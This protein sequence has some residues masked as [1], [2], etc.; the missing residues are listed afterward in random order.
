MCNM[1]ML[2]NKDW[3]LDIHYG[4]QLKGLKGL[5]QIDTD[6]INNNRVKRRRKQ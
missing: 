1:V 2:H 5:P 3:F 6:K 4:N